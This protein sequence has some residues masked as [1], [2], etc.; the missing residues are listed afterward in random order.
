MKNKERQ[1]HQLRFS[2]GSYS[3][4]I[5]STKIRKTMITRK[6]RI[7]NWTILF[8]FSFDKYDVESI[9]DALLWAE[10][11]DS[12]ISQ[13][14][15]NVC[16]GRLNEGFCFSQSS[17]RRSVAAVGMASNGPE[18]LNTTVHEIAH[19]AQHICGADGIDPMSEDVAY[20]IGDITI[21]ISDIVCQLSCPHCN[22][23]D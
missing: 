2:E 21:Q 22:R 11:P 12:I 16:A 15:E 20:I 4:P 9:Y 7:H 10:A 8:L 19:V 3:R 17:A 1:A 23:H 14:S 18:V 13:V 5:R 6:V